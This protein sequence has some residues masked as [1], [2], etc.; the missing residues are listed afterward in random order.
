VAA[1]P[2]SGAKLALAGL[3]MLAVPRFV[4]SM[5]LGDMTMALVLFVP[6]VVGLSCL[7][8][9]LYRLVK[10]RKQKPVND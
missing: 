3:A 2:V 10:S 6:T 1:Q 5:R 8:I 9:G 4:G 7:V